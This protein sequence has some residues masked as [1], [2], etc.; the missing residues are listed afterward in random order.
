[1]S[2]YDLSSCY[3]MWKK[4]WRNVVAKFPCTLP[5][6]VYYSEFFPQGKLRTTDNGGC[7][8]RFKQYRSLANWTVALSLTSILEGNFHTSIYFILTAKCF[9][10]HLVGTQT[11]SARP[12]STREGL[13]ILTWRLCLSR[14]EGPVLTYYKS[15]F[16]LP[17]RCRWDLR[18]SGFLRSV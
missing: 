4:L 3:K 15:D 17:L 5:V 7:L 2:I 12:F 9:M 16:R 6:H 11:V 13:S 8:V 14:V 1:M 18:S 10:L